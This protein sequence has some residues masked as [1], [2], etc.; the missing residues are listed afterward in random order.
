MRK[1]DVAREFIS[2]IIAVCTA[3]SML[4]SASAQSDNEP[5]V[6]PAQA[7]S[8]PSHLA[9]P[10]A[11]RN[12]RPAARSLTDKQFDTFVELVGDSESVVWQRLLAD[13]G[14]VPLAAAAA[15]ARTNRRRNATGMMAVGFTIVGLGS[16][17]TLFLLAGGPDVDGACS[18]SAG[19][20]SCLKVEGF[21][22]GSLVV[23]LAL[24]IPGLVKMARETEIE[25]GAVERYQSP[26][27]L[28]PST[29]LASNLTSASPRKSLQVPLLSFLF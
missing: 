27:I 15:N 2:R 3:L 13:P 10:T 18:A 14:L 29:P 25:R 1:P 9:S 17:I 8:A 5:L 20:S 19:K 28:L 6:S 16:T 11:K 23:G 22:V 24:A 26:G 21:F 4:S 7:E 12:G